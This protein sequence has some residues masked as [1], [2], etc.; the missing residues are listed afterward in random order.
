[1]SIDDVLPEDR[2]A[3]QILFKV[4]AKFAENYC[5]AQTERERAST[6]YEFKNFLDSPSI[7]P[8]HR[9]EFVALYELVKHD[10]QTVRAAQQKIGGQ[11]E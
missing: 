2:N 9:R 11:K 1:M 5:F 8:K 6:D 7:L 10:Y 3:E 4:M